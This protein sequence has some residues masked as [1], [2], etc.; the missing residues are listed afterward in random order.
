MAAKTIK[1]TVE[2]NDVEMNPNFGGVC[3]KM[4]R[5]HLDDGSTRIVGRTSEDGAKRQLQRLA[6]GYGLKVRGSVAQ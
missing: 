5:E 1:I 2:D 4:I 6:F 3:T